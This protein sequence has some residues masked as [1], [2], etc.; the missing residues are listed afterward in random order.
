MVW[1]RY[2]WW[3]SAT[4][5]LLTLATGMGLWEW[6]SSQ[7]SAQPLPLRARNVSSATNAITGFGGSAGNLWAVDSAGALYL[8]S[9]GGSS[10]IERTPPVS[11]AGFSAFNFAVAEYDST[12][13]LVAPTGENEKLFVSSDQGTTWSIGIVLP[14]A[15]TATRESWVGKGTGG[16]HVYVQL[17]SAEIGLVVFD[18]FYQAT[19]AF[20][21]LDTSLDGGRSFRAE[22]LP[23]FGPVRFLTL[24]NGFLSGG[25]GD[26]HLYR[27]ATSG[28]SWDELTLKP[29]TSGN[30]SIGFPYAS[31]YP[32]VIVPVT[33]SLTTGPSL[34]SA[35]IYSVK[36]NTGASASVG[37][38]LRIPGPVTIV[39][40]ARPVMVVEP[41]MSRVY[42]SQ[43]SGQTW[44][45]EAIVGLPG[46]SGLSSVVGTGLQSAV[47]WVVQSRC[48][49]KINCTYHAALYRTEDSGA[50]WSSV[51]L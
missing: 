7:H 43:S 11:L 48:T 30:F 39:T 31:S 33:V 3:L 37:R 5:A 4:I 50:S 45:T 32:T 27:T 25:P 40:T 17:L 18:Q 14:S 15:V 22:R 41:A 1:L 20:A 19:S 35:E 16:D 42:V 46:G 9:N 10:W 28:S 13:W 38:P 21:T 6:N 24:T 36:L 23:T 26:Q 34:S 47:A 29:F 8:T 49:N 12:V 51:S 44:N 2:R